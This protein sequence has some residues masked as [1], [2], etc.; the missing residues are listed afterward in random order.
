M[1]IAV[2]SKDPHLQLGVHAEGATWIVAGAGCGVLA[3]GLA[4]LAH[5]QKVIVPAHAGASTAVGLLVMNLIRE[6]QISFGY[7]PGLG[8][9]DT[10]R[11]RQAFREL[12]DQASA[13]AFRLGYDTDDLICE[14][15]VDICVPGK[16]SSTIWTIQCG[17]FNTIAGIFEQFDQLTRVTNGSDSSSKAIVGATVRSTIET[18]KPRLPGLAHSTSISGAGEPAD[19]IVIGPGKML[20]CLCEIDVPAGW[21]AEWEPCGDVVMTRV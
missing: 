15:Y 12:M 9:D 4:E 21:R 19:R 13:E 8:V 16:D 1:A 6:H 20:A 11:L 17:E 7:S 2:A 3:W 10:T 14:S 18:P 5:V